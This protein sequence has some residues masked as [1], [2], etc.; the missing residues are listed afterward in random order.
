[1]TRVLNQ[2]A[3]VKSVRRRI[4]LIQSWSMIAILAVVIPFYEQLIASGATFTIASL[5]SMTMYLGMASFIFI[6][7]TGFEQMILLPDHHHHH[8]LGH[9]DHEFGDAMAD[10]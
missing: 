6:V 7:A 9:L 3:L 4:I 1:M 5:M 8:H 10:A 2:F